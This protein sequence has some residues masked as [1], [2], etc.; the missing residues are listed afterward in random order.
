MSVCSLDNCS[1]ECFEEEKECILH[2]DEQVLNNYLES[3]TSIEDGLIMKGISFPDSFDYQ[4]VFDKLERILFFNCTFNAIDKDIHSRFNSRIFFYSC[5]F[6]KYWIHININLI[7]YINCTFKDKV[8]FTK[9]TKNENI[10]TTI[11]TNS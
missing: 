11:S 8:Y 10:V 9:D 4:I 5:E 7:S 2:C 3:N 1:N 6:N